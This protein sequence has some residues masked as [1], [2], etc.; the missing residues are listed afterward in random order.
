[1]RHVTMDC[2]AMGRSRAIRRRGQWERGVRRV[3]VRLVMT[4]C[5]ARSMRAMK[6]W[7]HVRTW[8]TMLFAAT[9]MRAMASKHA[10]RRLGV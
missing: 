1:M 2:I 5:R 3:R 4:A 9:T 8:Q 7:I 10:M 6:R